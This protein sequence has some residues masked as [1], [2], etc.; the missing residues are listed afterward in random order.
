M[1]ITIYKPLAIILL[2]ILAGCSTMAGSVIGG[3]I[4]SAM[5]NAQ[6]GRDIGAAVGMI[7]DIWGY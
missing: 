3:G 2:M 1:R 6:M 5:G 7:D 4:G